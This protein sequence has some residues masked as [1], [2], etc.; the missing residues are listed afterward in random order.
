[1]ITDSE[2]NRLKAISDH[3]LGVGDQQLQQMQ[4]R[5]DLLTEAVG[6]I[7]SLHQ[8]QTQIGADQDAAAENQQRT[9]TN[10]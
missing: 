5:L 2:T 3:S 7:V 4:Q 6:H 1:M 9:G 8:Q 10:G